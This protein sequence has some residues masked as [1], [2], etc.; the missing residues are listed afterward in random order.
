MTVEA[1]RSVDSHCSRSGGFN[2]V[3]LIWLVFAKMDW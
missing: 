2:L 3:A 1:L